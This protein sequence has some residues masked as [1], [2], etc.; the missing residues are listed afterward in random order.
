MAHPRFLRVRKFSNKAIILSKCSTLIFP[1]LPIQRSGLKR[2]SAEI[3]PRHT[4]AKAY[5]CVSSCRILEL[6][7]ESSSRLGMDKANVYSIPDLKV[8]RNEGRKKTMAYLVFFAFLLFLW[9]A[10]VIYLL[11]LTFGFS[12][13]TTLGLVG[14]GSLRP[15]FFNEVG[16]SHQ[17]T[18]LGKKL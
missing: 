16:G 1:A 13:K 6:L 12:K 17:V 9:F 18:G 5:N 15:S 10:S 4:G 11:H 8:A 2:T 14:I 3:H 7:R